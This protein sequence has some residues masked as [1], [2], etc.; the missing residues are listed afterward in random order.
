MEIRWKFNGNSW[1]YDG[2]TV[3]IHGNS[4]E[5]RLFLAVGGADE[6]V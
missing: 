1:K 5:I 3:E 2:N 4:V 6:I